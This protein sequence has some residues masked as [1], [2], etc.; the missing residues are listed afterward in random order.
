M[1][2]D[3]LDALFDGYRYASVELR[4]DDGRSLC[5]RFTRHDLATPQAWRAAMR[6]QLGHTGYRPPVY[7]Q[8]AHDQIVRVMFMLGEATQ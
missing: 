8:D 7:D 5:V 1:S 6:R 4:H 3:E 2:P